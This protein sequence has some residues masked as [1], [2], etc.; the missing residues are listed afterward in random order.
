[1]NELKKIKC[2]MKAVE[3]RVKKKK[4]KREKEIKQ[5]QQALFRELKKTY[6]E[7]LKRLNLVEKNWMMQNRI[8]KKKMNDASNNRVRQVT[9]NP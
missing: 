7:R 4:L 8:S 6:N 9:V 3:T 5:L 1:M 2:A